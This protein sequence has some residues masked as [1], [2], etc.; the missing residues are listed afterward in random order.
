MRR[1]PSWR[2]RTRRLRQPAWRTRRPARGPPGAATDD[3]LLLVVNARRNLH[4]WY[5][6]GQDR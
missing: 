5:W 2:A 1:G 3:D 4:F 6:P